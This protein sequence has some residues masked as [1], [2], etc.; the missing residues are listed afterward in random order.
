MSLLHHVYYFYDF[1]YLGFIILY[2]LY[3]VLKETWSIWYHLNSKTVY[4]KKL[5]QTSESSLSS[6]LSP[7][8]SLVLVGKPVNKWVLVE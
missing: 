6:C 1:S 7:T 2:I 3:L 4:G 5:L 8:L